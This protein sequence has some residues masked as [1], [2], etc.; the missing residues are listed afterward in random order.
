MF[1]LFLEDSHVDQ[2]ADTYKDFDATKITKVLKVYLSK[3]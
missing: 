2:D 3:T 1:E